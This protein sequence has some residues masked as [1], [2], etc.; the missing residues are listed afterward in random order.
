MN[1]QTQNQEA[2]AQAQGFIANAKAYLNEERG[3]LT[4][5]VSD[6]V[7]IVMPVNLYKKILGIPFTKA[8]KSE[9]PKQAAKTFGLQ[10]RP[11][12]FLSKDGRYL[13]H[14]VLGVRIT[15]HVNFYKKI[16]GAEFTP[17]VRSEKAA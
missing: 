15:K 14:Q 13:T 5:V 9:G 16:L 3:T 7:R 10:A 1:Q 11:A 17:D 6:E 8:E 4:H 2:A 12:I